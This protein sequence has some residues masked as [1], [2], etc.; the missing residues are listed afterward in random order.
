M[1][2]ALPAPR[3][4]GFD[5][6]ARACLLRKLLRAQKA[7]A[8]KGAC[9]RELAK[10]AYYE[11][12]LPTIVGFEAARAWWLAGRALLALREGLRRVERAAFGLALTL[13][14]RSK[15]R[16]PKPRL[17]PGLWPPG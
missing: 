11:V 10:Q 6:H 8:H 1:P 16:T 12:Y 2:P 15:T 3:D 14:T 5:G 7:A 13:W 9:P 17:H 4:Y